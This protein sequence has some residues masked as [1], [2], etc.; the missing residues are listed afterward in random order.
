MRMMLTYHQEKKSP[1]T[2]VWS[3][4]FPL[5]L[6]ELGCCCARCI[7]ILSFV[8]FSFHLLELYILCLFLVMSPI[9]SLLLSL[10]P[11]SNL[12]PLSPLNLLSIVLAVRSSF[13]LPFL[14]KHQ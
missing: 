9:L 10:S 11:L 13:I 6:S 8:Q 2:Q 7:I 4:I 3:C 12:Y 14:K 1:L 5:V